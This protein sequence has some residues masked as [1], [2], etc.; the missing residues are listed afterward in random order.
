MKEGGL[1]EAMSLRAK[2]FHF[3]FLLSR[4]M[5]LGVRMAAINQ[6]GKIM[7]VKHTYVTGWH[8]PG[9]GVD[10]GE[11][12]R[13]AA[14]RE[15]AEE[16]GLKPQ[17]EPQLFAIYFNKIASNR[18]HVVLFQ[19]QT[20]SD[21]VTKIPDKEI[22]EARF[23]SLDNLPNDISAGTRR[24]LAEMFEGAEISPHW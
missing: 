16:T 18:D 23:F 21:G 9:G 12:C 6:D 19:C 3:W 7:L 4:P 11:G 5:T 1:F 15:L 13:E 8:L 2:L 10:A 24:R 20:S 22:A 17:E 14:V